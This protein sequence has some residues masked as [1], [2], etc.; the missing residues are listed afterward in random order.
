M[1]VQTDKEREIFKLKEEQQHE[2]KLI[3]YER[4]S[5]SLVNDMA[6]HWTQSCHS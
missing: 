1:K 5:K 3:S 6:Y 2:N 4:K